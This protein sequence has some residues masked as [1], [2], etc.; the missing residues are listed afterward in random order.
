MSVATYIPELWVAA[1]IDPLETNLVYGQPLVCNRD[2]EGVISEFGDTVTVNTVGE[3]SINDYVPYV[4]EVEPERINTAARKLKIDQAKYY[5]FE[6]DDVDKRQARGDLMTKSMKRA[7]FR[8]A[9]TIDAYLASFYTGIPSGQVL[10]D[11]STSGTDEEAWGKQAYWNLVDLGVLMTENDIPKEGRYATIPAWYT[12]L[13]QKNPNF[14]RVSEYGSSSVLLNGE[15]GR[16]AGFTLLE[17]NNCPAPT[18]STNFVQAGIADALSMAHQIT[19]S[20]AFR[21]EKGFADAVKGLDVYGAK[22]MRPDLV[23]GVEVTRPS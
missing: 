6:I 14:T 12:G 8:M 10:P 3:V 1:L 11:W 22:L 15:V 5:S 9:S 7:G 16:A 17:T 20:E 18:G 2:Y 23:A 21:P 13:L 4:T 19:E